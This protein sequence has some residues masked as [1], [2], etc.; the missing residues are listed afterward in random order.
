MTDEEIVSQ[1]LKSERGDGSLTLLAFIL[2]N[3][4]SSER[5]QTVYEMLDVARL[6]ESS[7]SGLDEPEE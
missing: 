2:L 1:L 3:S 5:K 7:G 4:M 6:L